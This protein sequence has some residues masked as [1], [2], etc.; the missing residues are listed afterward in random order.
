MVFLWYFHI[1]GLQ[2][3]PS[4]S[5]RTC[6]E[7]PKMSQACPGRSSANTPHVTSRR[8]TPAGSRFRIWVTV[9]RP[10]GLGRRICRSEF[11]VW[12]HLRQG[13]WLVTMGMVHIC[14]RCVCVY[15][16][17]YICVCVCVWLYIIYIYILNRFE[18]SLCEKQL[19]LLCASII[20][21]SELHAVWTKIGQAPDQ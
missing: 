15:M 2:I 4:A 7:C 3:D 5:L 9:G 11:Y 1:F 16:C 6:S 12:L 18:I 20:F 14:Y 19:G 17:I 13:D 10:H 8:A 21:D